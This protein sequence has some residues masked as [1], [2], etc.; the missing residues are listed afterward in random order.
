[1]IGQTMSYDTILLKPVE[2]GTGVVD[3]TSDTGPGAGYLMS[4][5]IFTISRTS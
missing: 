3:E 5:I 4:L 2:E 1:M